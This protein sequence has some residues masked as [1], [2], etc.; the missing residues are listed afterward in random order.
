MKHW[1]L[2]GLLSIAALQAGAQP[3]EPF[4]SHPVTAIV[5]FPPGGYADIVMRAL[6]P[7]LGRAL[8]QPVVIMNRPGA[9]GALGAAVATQAKPDGYTI[10]YTLASIITLPEQ[11]NLNN[12]KPIFT[13]DQLAPIAKVTTDYPAIVVPAESKYK[14]IADLVAAAKANPGRITFASS[15]NYGSSHVPVAMFSDAAG[16]K[17]NHIP[18]PGGA[19]MIV[20]MLS[21]EVDFAAMSRSFV[22]TQVQSGKMRY[23]ASYGKRHWDEP[24]IPSLADYG[25]NVDYE[26]W[27]GAFLPANTP[28]PIANRMRE[29]FKT[30]VNDPEFKQ[31]LAKLGGDIDYIDGEEMNRFWQ[32][33][34]RRVNEAVRKIGK[35]E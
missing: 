29:A 27:T 35:V 6:Q 23:L 25:I 4:P 18:Y 22:R 31:A 5:P 7:S 24:K 19:Q 26:P 10:L 33:D 32:A 17:F 16:A 14:T 3:A 28:A 34:V 20:A 8:G 2:A 21:N 1:I 30:A 15:G 9:G 12:Q 11:A 13:L